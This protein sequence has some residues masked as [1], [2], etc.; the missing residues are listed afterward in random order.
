MYLGIPIGHGSLVCHKQACMRCMWS[1]HTYYDSVFSI[2]KS[3]Y[4][5]R[6]FSVIAK[7][8]LEE[9][10]NYFMLLMLEEEATYYSAEKL[11][12]S[13]TCICRI[14]SHLDVTSVCHCAQVSKVG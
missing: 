7:R 14:F 6:R 2:E 10:N 8:V 5:L 3:K 4:C 11:Y 9:T 13:A 12:N 1:C